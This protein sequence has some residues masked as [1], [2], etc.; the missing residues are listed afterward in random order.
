MKAIDPMPDTGACGAQVVEL[1]DAEVCELGHAGLGQQHVLRL[2]VAVHDALAVRRLQGREHLDAVVHRLTWRE[3]SFLQ[4]VLEAARHELHHQEVGVAVSV[5]VEHPQDVGVVEAG[6]RSGFREHA[7]AQRFPAPRHVEQHLE[8]PGHT[9]L[10]VP[11]L[12]HLGLGSGTQAGLESISAGEDRFGV[13]H[14][15]GI[16]ATSVVMRGLGYSP[17]TRSTSSTQAGGR[18]RAQ[19]CSA[20]SGQRP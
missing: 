8:G 16:I 1:G 3:R 7:R 17:T 14:E 20:S 5:D 2:D 18:P 19:S 15:S 4:Q 6:H 10:L 13:A 12:P 9:Q 11:G